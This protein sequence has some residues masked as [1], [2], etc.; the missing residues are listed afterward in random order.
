MAQEAQ[1]AAG[2]VRA[3]DWRPD[4]PRVA[5]MRLGRSSYAGEEGVP[6]SCVLPCTLLPPNKETCGRRGWH[7][8]ARGDAQRTRSSQAH[9]RSGI[10]EFAVLPAAARPPR[11]GGLSPRHTS[12]PRLATSGGA[13]THPCFAVIGSDVAT[14]LDR[15]CHDV[16]CY[17]RAG[18]G[19]CPGR[20]VWNK[21]KT[22]RVLHTTPQHRESLLTL[23]DHWE[24]DWSNFDVP[25]WTATTT[26][27]DLEDY[28]GHIFFFSRAPFRRSSAVPVHEYNG[29]RAGSGRWQAACEQGAASACGE[30][31]VEVGHHSRLAIVSTRRQLEQ[32]RREG[33]HG[34]ASCAPCQSGR[35]W[36]TTSMH[37]ASLTGT[38][39]FMSA[40][41]ALRATRAPPSRQTRA[42]ACSSGRARDAKTPD[43]A[44]AERWSPSGSRRPRQRQTRG[45]RGSGSRRRR[46]KSTRRCSGGRATAADVGRAVRARPECGPACESSRARDAGLR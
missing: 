34:S 18:Q 17:S 2:L 22:K 12:D 26:V 29:L 4:Q 39:M 19:A 9:C 8:D 13:G 20:N 21:K 15:A 46:S 35:P 45:A 30:D 41:R 11:C 1:Y 28:N 5:G 38:S 7:G 25:M 6:Q 31:L 36:A 32:R 42:T 43:V 10:G 27:W 24:V 3:A 23:L 40:T 14:S 16:A 44:H 33:A 37:R